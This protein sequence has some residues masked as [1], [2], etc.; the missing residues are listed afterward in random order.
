MARGG[1]GGAER[2]GKAIALRSATHSH[3]GVTS[4]G[5][6]RTP[7]ESGSP[8]TVQSGRSGPPEHLRNPCPVGW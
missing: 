4:P 8:R 3:D 1:C 6:E 5:I 7:C 2:S